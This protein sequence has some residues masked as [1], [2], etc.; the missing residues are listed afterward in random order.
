MRHLL[1]VLVLPV[2]AAVLVP[3]WIAHRSGVTATW[4]VGAA[5]RLAA[6]GG[7]VIGAVGLVL[8]ASCLARFGREG[9]GTLAPWD[10]P[11]ELVVSGAYRYVRNPMIS[12]VLLVL[13]AEAMVLRSLPH[14]VW[15]LAFA[16][17]NAV[18]IP[19]VEEPGLEARFGDP[20]RRYRRHVPRFVPRLRPWHPARPDPG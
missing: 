4:P 20:Y 17:L 9:H 13:V 8:F 7:S 6:A 16:F 3:V 2:T 11:A 19:A 12:G 5:G 18:Y 10:P 1:A 15:A 14:L